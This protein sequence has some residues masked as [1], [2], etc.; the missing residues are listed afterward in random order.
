MKRPFAL[1][2]DVDGT[3]AETERFGHR[4]AFNEAFA[5]AG[6]DWFWDEETYGRLLEIPGGQQRLLAFIQQHALDLGPRDSVLK[7]AEQLHRN[8]NQHYRQLL[9]DGRIKL[10]PGVLRLMLDARDAGMRLGICT[11]GGPD[12]VLPLLRATLGSD[13]DRLFDV[14][15]LQEGSLPSKP[16]PDLYLRAVQQL[17]LDPADCMAIEDSAI[18]VRAAAAAGIPVIA[19]YNDYSEHQDFGPAI[20]EVDGFG[21]PTE[22]V[23]TRRGIPPASGVIDVAALQSWWRESK[24]HQARRNHRRDAPAGAAPE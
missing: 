19:C 11:T 6:L 20:A 14:I 23:G 13:G 7:L 9:R 18:G 22:P 1:I 15:A 21:T 8:K 2:F 17:A 10:R 5:T 4:V 12:S 3:L 24:P 16:F